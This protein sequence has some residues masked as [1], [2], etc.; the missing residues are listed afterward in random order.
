MKADLPIFIDLSI[1]IPI[2][3]D[4][5]GT[6]LSKR[7]IHPEYAKTSIDTSKM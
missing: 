4:S 2:C 6:Y 7:G 5:T 1:D 3:I